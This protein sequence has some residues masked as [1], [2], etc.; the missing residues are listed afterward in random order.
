MLKKNAR[1]ERMVAKGFRPGHGIW[2]DTY[3]RQFGGV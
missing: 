1:F 2:I 3:N